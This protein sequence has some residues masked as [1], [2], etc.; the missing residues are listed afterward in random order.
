ME[1]TKKENLN[2]V[3]LPCYMAKDDEEY[4]NPN[5]QKHFV[6]V[7]KDIQKHHLF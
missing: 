2:F 4:M 1:E 6:Q 3:G 7:L 5:Q